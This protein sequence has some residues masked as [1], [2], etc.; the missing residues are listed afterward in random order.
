MPKPLVPGNCVRLISDHDGTGLVM[1]VQSISGDDVT[2]VWLD[3]QRAI[4]SQLLKTADIVRIVRWMDLNINQATENSDTL[5]EERDLDTP[6]ITAEN[7]PTAYYGVRFNKIRTTWEQ[8]HQWFA[9]DAGE[10]ADFN[11]TPTIPGDGGA[12]AWASTAW[13]VGGPMNH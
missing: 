2:C 4:Q 7:D 9:P 13:A 3:G 10:L 11:Q 8:I 6:G 5:W 12:N 1:V